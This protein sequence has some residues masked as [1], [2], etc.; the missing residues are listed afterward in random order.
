MTE[1]YMMYYGCWDDTGHY[2]YDEHGMSMSRREMDRLMKMP[3]GIYEVDGGM[4]P[5]NNQVEGEAVLVCKEDWTVLTFWDRTIDHRPGS[6]SAYVAKGTFTFD[7]MVAMA[8]ARFSVRWNRMK[9]EVK[10]LLDTGK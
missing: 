8:K 5:R 10:P 4:Q 9:F 7:Q 3:W 2:Y 1:P 6:L